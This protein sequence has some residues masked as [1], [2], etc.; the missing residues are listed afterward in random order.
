[1]GIGKTNF[2]LE[3]RVCKGYEKEVAQ[4]LRVVTPTTNISILKL[5]HNN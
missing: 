1:M 4:G 2:V 5:Q 3:G